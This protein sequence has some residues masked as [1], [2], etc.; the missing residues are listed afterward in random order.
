M[1]NRLEMISDTLESD[2]C[3]LDHCYDLADYFHVRINAVILI[4]SFIKHLLRARH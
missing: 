3:Y 2:N 1:K 4:H